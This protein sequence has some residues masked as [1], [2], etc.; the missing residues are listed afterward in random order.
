VQA[1]ARRAIG[2]GAGKHIRSVGAQRR[3]DHM[4]LQKAVKTLND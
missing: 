1:L 2:S 4:A 3:A